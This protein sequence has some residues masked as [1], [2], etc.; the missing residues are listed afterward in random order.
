MTDFYSYLIILQQMIDE[1][2]M[3]ELI[4]VNGNVITMDKK[5]PRAAAVVIADGRIRFVGT[6]T[7]ATGEAAPDAQRI[8]LAGK[9]VIPGFNDNHLHTIPFGH[10]ISVPDLSGLDQKQILETLRDYY[11]D[12]APRDLILAYRWDYTRCPHPDK[13]ILDEA[14]PDNPV[15][16]VQFSG[17]GL[18]LNSSALKMMGISRNSGNVTGRTVIRDNSG[19]PTG[20]IREMSI[21]RYIARHFKRINRKRERSVPFINRSLEIY[22]IHGITSVQDNTWFFQTVGTLKKMVSEGEL[23][24]RFSCWAYGENNLASFLLRRQS[25]VGDWITMGPEKFFLD[26]TFS[27]RSAWLSEPYTNDPGNCGGGRS[28]EEIKAL[29]LPVVKKR[30]QAAFH[31][32][33]DRAVK[34]FL[35]AVE[36]LS[37]CYP[38][39]PDLRLR[40]EH[41]QLIRPE[42]IERIRHLGIIV[43]AQ[44]SALEDPAKDV[45]L[46]GTGRARRAYPYRSLLD[47]GVHLS[48]GSDVPGERS[49]NPLLCLHYAV[50]RQGDEAIDIEEGLRCYTAGSAYAEFKENKKGRIAEGMLADLAVLSDDPTRVE[51][52]RIKDISVEMTVVDGHIV[53]KKA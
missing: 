7:E 13:S 34:E 53:Y 33:G 17:H 9:T 5:K 18:W 8:D 26:G 51:K 37:G 10:H 12:A 50:N 16:L 6:N 39:I 19:E 25:P 11:R 15:I 30:R 20:I 48:F 52:D 40:L 32:I 14:F 49:V 28:R 36:E 45:D 42:D 38:Y 29:L 24:C 4:L 35:D 31:A 1:E 21:N 43:A 3:G 23:T 2:H 46:L 41:A 47:N 44:P 22:R 27:A